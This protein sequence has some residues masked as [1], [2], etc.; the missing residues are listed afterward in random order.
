MKH[1]VTFVLMVV[2]WCYPVYALGPEMIGKPAPGF[3]LAPLNGGAPVSLA[4]LRGNAVVIDFWASWCAPCKRSLPQLAA[5]A[6]ST[7]G[8]KLLAVNIDDEKENAIAFLK[9]LKMTFSSLHDKSKSVSATY[10]VPAMPSAVILDKRGVVRFVH[11]GYTE[12]DI[13]QIKDEIRSL[14]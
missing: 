3:T 5:F 11:P 10:D 8:V 4:E 7:S 12:S 2:L 13:E 9:R 14:L 6:S 1:A